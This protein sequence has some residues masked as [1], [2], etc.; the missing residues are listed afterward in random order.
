MKCL[1]ESPARAVFAFF[2]LV[3]ATASCG[4]DGADP[5]RVE[6]GGLV[7]EARLDPVVPRTGENLLELLVL[8]AGGRPVPDAH[9]EVKVIMPAMGAM[10]QMGGPARVRPLGEGRY[11]ATFGLDMDGSYRIDVSVHAASSSLSAEGSLMTGRSGFSLTARRAPPPRSSSHAPT[12]EGAADAAAHDPHGG[13]AGHTRAPEEAS[14]PTDA[15]GGFAGEVFVDPGRRQR[16]GIR[17]APVRL[18]PF[19]VTIRAVGLV[20]YDRGAIQD[21]APRVGGT[22]GS[23]RVPAP[24]NPVRAGDLLF[25]LYSPELLAAQREYLTALGSG[26]SDA[27]ATAAR[28]R[29][30]LWGMSGADIDHV[31]Q[32]GVPLEYVPFRSPVSGV[33]IEKNVVDGSGTSANERLFRIAAVDRVWIEAELYEADLALVRPGDAAEIALVYLPGE[34]FEGTVSLVNP[35]LDGET[36]TA[37]ARIELANRDGIL[38]PGMYATV[39]LRRDLGRRIV[40]PASAVLYAGDRRFVFVD[41]GEG[42]LRPRAITTGHRDGER[43]EVLSGLDAG[44]A[45]VVSGNYLIASESRLGTA[46]EQW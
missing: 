18:E 26:R 16:T 31:A 35:F 24:G 22:V 25:T 14:A 27:V 30:R 6:G 44:E 42:R 46:L 23:V 37:R 10:A 7:V 8:D 3:T 41:A 20:E 21:I 34:R 38:L 9:V 12:G 4:R 17:I 40:V 11:E 39:W 29:L 13:H 2:L 5:V 45:I 43:L 36:R 28:G 32:T 1:L 33:V 15:G 19:E